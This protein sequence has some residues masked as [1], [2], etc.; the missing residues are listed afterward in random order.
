M[1]PPLGA[2]FR[3]N[4][5]PFPTLLTGD[6]PCSCIIVIKYIIMFDLCT[7]V[8][9]VKFPGKFSVNPPTNPPPLPL[10][11]RVVLDNDRSSCWVNL[12]VLDET[13][14]LKAHLLGLFV[15]YRFFYLAPRSSFT[16]HCR[17]ELATQ[18]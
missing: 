15:E 2:Y 14:R 11:G 4:P 10:L 8:I 17:E 13:F 5:H 1:S 16:I 9:V 6:L 3:T 18:V 7:L 12:K